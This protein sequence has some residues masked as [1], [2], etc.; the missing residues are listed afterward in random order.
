MKH[1][2]LTFLLLILP[3]FVI[4]QNSNR[5]FETMTNKK[6]HLEIKVNDGAYKIRL[7]SN[8][9]IETSFIPSGEEDVKISHAVVLKSISI[10]NRFLKETASSLVL[11]TEGISLKIQKKPFQISYFYKG[12]KIT[13]EKTGYSK[14]STHQKIRLN[15]TKEE[16]LYG[17]GARV[18]GMNRRGNRL[19]LY[20]RAHYGYETHSEL[21]NF[22]LP[23][24]L[25]SKM[26]L[27]HFDNAPIGFLDLDSKKDNSITYETISGRKTYQVIVGDSWIDLI[28]SYTNLTGK[29]PLPP[30]WTF[31]NFS[32]RFGYHSQKETETTIDK[33]KEEEIPVEQPK[34]YGIYGEV[35]FKQGA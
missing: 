25:S 14:D 18:L 11:N 35:S 31:G 6:T 15:L 23:I 29:Q 2:K 32:S 8:K 28:D 19:Q 12:N 21:M 17:G 1:F 3:A 4:A 26:Y 5:I 24:V 33:F 30:R 13:S 16:V 34:E 27:L 22:T 7:F 20:N 10:D 9:I